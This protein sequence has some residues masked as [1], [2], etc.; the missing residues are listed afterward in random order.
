ME[1]T[2]GGDQRA[3]RVNSLPSGVPPARRAFAT[4][5]A[6][7]RASSFASCC[8]PSGVVARVPTQFAEP[9]SRQC[10]YFALG[11]AAA[12]R[13]LLALALAATAAGADDGGAAAAAF[14]AAYTAVLARASA[15]KRASPDEPYIETVY[16]PRPLRAARAALRVPPRARYAGG[17][18][19]HALD[20]GGGGDTALELDEFVHTVA[21]AGAPNLYD[22]PAVWGGAATAGAADYAADKAVKLSTREVPWAGMRAALGA[23]LEA[24]A[25]AGGGGGVRVA[26]IH[27][28]VMA[29]A[30][31]A[32]PREGRFLVLDSHAAES[33]FMD[34]DGLERYI[35][36]DADSAPGGGVYMVVTWAVGR[37][38]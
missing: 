6:P 30:V 35:A 2:T 13:E 8:A 5:P 19:A 25:G 36:Y 34:A 21:N 27:R 22:D 17:P 1:G 32:A 3:V 20:G 9:A 29:F 24:D 15:A 37:A 28:L 12:A 14:V 11:A 4:L 38:R 26:V 31:V 33:G 23:L 10:S 16:S 18:A 7:A